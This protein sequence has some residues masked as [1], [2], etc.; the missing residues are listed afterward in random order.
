MKPES[1]AIAAIVVN[2]P[3]NFPEICRIRWCIRIA[4]IVGKIYPGNICPAE[5][6]RFAI[7]LYPVILSK[8]FHCKK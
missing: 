7:M 8:H 6:N 5:E 3:E 1:H 2:F 4:N